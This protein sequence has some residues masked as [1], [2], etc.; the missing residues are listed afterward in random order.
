MRHDPV[1]IH[2]D[3]SLRANET[4]AAHRSDRLA[5]IRHGM[6]HDAIGILET[7]R[8]PKKFSPPHGPAAHNRITFL[9]TKARSTGA[10]AMQASSE[11]CPDEMLKA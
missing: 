3:P 2:A 6:D 11:A 7:R 5:G 4:G 10:C 9:A 8:A 1:P